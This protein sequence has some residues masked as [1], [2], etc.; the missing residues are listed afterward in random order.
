MLSTTPLRLY[1]EENLL[2]SLPALQVAP[3]KVLTLMGPS[4]CGKSSLLAAL[5]G[6][7]PASGPIR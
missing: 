3:G 7:M 1:L 6:V 4:G 2:L 5:A